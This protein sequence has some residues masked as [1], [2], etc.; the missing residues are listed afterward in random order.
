MLE[1]GLNNSPY[2]H[3]AAHTRDERRELSMDIVIRPGATRKSVVLGVPPQKYVL[4]TY[5]HITYSSV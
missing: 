1:R 2:V 5:K 4:R 3:T